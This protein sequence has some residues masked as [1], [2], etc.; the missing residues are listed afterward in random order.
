[1]IVLAFAAL[2]LLLTLI[3]TYVLPIRSDTAD[4]ISA[5]GLSV[6]TGLSALHAA[7]T[8]TQTVVVLTDPVW[9]SADFIWHSHPG[10]MS[11]SL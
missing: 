5:R 10:V 7:V 11:L 1:M 4:P 6:N 9:A 8:T 3:G 2:Y